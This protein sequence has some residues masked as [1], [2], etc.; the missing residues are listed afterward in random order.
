MRQKPDGI[1]NW[2]GQKQ[3]KMA[4]INRVNMQILKILYK[5]P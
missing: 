1:R 3:D 4:L 5:C 2:I